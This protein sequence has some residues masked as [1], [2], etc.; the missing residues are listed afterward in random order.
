MPRESDSA[1]Q[2]FK[3]VFRGY[4]QPFETADGKLAMMTK[5]ERSMYYHRVADLC[6]NETLK[7]ELREGKRKLMN[8][9]AFEANSEI[10]RAAYRATLLWITSFEQ[11]L[12]SL[13]QQGERH[14]PNPLAKL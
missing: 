2:A 13:K 7:A 3:E 14:E 9:L 4:D 12:M 5:E 1:L 10:E 6:T 11:R 8:H